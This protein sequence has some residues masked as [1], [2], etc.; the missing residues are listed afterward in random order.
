MSSSLS[1]SEHLF[2][3]SNF[4]FDNKYWLYYFLYLWLFLLVPYS[5]LQCSNAWENSN[6]NNIRMNLYHGGLLIVEI[7]KLCTLQHLR[8]FT[9]FTWV[10]LIYLIEISVLSLNLK[11]K[12][13][14]WYTSHPLRHNL[15]YQ[16][17]L[18]IIL[19]TTDLLQQ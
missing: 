3:K 7:S 12:L 6:R 8:N 2:Y 9:S 5:F 14:K 16:S 19:V 18:K 1:I 15:L 11:C 13:Q 17:D 4:P 10:P